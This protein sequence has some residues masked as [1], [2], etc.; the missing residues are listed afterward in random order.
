M[1]KRKRSTKKGPTRSKKVV[2]IIEDEK[3]SVE[4]VEVAKP[5]KKLNKIARKRAS[6]KIPREL[7]IRAS[8]P[9]FDGKT[10]HLGTVKGDVANRIIICSDEKIAWR[11]SRFFDNPAE[12]REIHSPRHFITYTG[13]FKGTPI[14]VIAS[15][16]GEPMIDFTMREAKIHLD[17]PMAVVRYG[18]CG[19][20]SNCEEGQ[21]VVATDGCFECTF[22][23]EAKYGKSGGNSYYRISDVAPSDDKLNA[24]LTKCIK[25]NLLD[26]DQCKTGLLGTSDSFYSSQARSHT[27]FSDKNENLINEIIKKYPNAKTMDMESYTVVGTALMA[28]KKDVYASAVSHVV[29]NRMH[30]GEKAPPEKMLEIQDLAGYGIFKALHKFDFP[31]GEPVDTLSLIKKIKSGS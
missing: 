3:E 29:V 14:S 15:G 5:A 17:G 1:P 2:S 25:S 9:L 13:L 31:E 24:H 26:P 4:S 19:S 23:L 10:M 16:M 27:K 12:V 21:V 28:K 30:Y 7:D 11:L 18:S 20:I 22:D 6:K 8:F